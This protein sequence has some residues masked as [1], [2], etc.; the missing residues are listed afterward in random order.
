MAKVKDFRA[1]IRIDNREAK[2]KFEETREQVDKLTKELEELRDE[3]KKDTQEYKKLNQ[4]LNELKKTFIT[5]RDL[6]GKTAYTY[7]ELKKSASNVRRELNN[8]IPGTKKWQ[9]LDR[10]S[11][12]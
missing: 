11:V 10:K 8:T 6:V 4:E 5:Q 7:N 9:E 2:S 3:G 12:V 1:A